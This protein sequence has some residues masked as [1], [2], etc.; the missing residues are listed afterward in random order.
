MIQLYH[1]CILFSRN[2]FLRALI[3]A[4]INGTNAIW[5]T[6][7]PHW[8]LCREDYYTTTIL[9]RRLPMDGRFER[10]EDHAY[11]HAYETNGNC[12]MLYPACQYSIYDMDFWPISFRKPCHKLRSTWRSHV[13]WWPTCRWDL[14]E[15]FL[16][17]E[18]FF[19]PGICPGFVCAIPRRI[20]VFDYW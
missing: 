8:E 4:L 1:T 10:S 14:G 19:R 18:R 2:I 13:W 17:A 11:D 9:F 12:E 16:V 6:L 5:Q 15:V 20:S 3:N 7:Y